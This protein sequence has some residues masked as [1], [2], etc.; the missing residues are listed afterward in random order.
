M[1]FW[2]YNNSESTSE[3][4][5]I[6]LKLPFL[7]FTL[8]TGFHSMLFILK[9]FMYEKKTC[10]CPAW[11]VQICS[12]AMFRRMVSNKYEPWTYSD[13]VIPVYTH[14]ALWGG[15][16]TS[17]TM[18]PQCQQKNM[19][20]WTLSSENYPVHTEH[21]RL[22]LKVGHGAAARGVSEQGTVLLMWNWGVDETSCASVSW[23]TLSVRLTADWCAQKH[24]SKNRP[25]Y[26]WYA[27][28]RSS[29]QTLSSSSSSS[30]S[31]KTFPL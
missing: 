5:D 22:W 18:V 28:T 10:F 25:K 4:R 20:C 21:G 31:Y 1:Q 7:F 30:K 8:E 9:C 16:V 15:G 11:P 27:K 17:L 29:N 19:I 13:R 24:S 3:L 2:L 26:S 12:A 23:F 6:K 14:L